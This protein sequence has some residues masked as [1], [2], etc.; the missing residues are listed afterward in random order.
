[1]NKLILSLIVGILLISCVTALDSLGTFKQN[2]AVRVTQV[3]ADATYINI[4]SIALPNS[5][6]AVNNIA[7]TS[8]GSGEFYYD[9]INTSDLGRYD[10]RGISDGCDFTFATYF[11]ITPSGYNGNSNI[12]FFIV[13]IILIYGITLWGFFGK[14]I[15]MTILGGMAML[16]LGI[17][18]FN[19]GVIIYRDDITRYLSYVTIGIGAIL[20]V[21]ASYEWYQDM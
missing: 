14:S 8:A 20:G 16:F 17:Y 4:S 3:C 15:P 19:N 11:D 1:M 6:I 2:E 18:L 13:V 21:W 10:V 7:M 5:T 12:A 9:F